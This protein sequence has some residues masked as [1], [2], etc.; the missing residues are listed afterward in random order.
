MNEESLEE[1]ARRREERR[2][3][4]TGKLRAVP[5]A[6]GSHRGS[7]VEPDAPRA[8]EEW[9]GAQWVIV[10]LVDDLAAA[11][12]LL[13]PPQPVMEKAEWDRP[14]GGKGRGRHRR[15]AP[16]AEDC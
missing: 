16:A 9:D 8:V 12:G 11:K 2:A 5:L 1:W 4:S 14:V 6:S 15:S 7:H 10:G 13:H 3:Q